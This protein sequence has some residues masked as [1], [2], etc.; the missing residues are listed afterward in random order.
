MFGELSFLFLLPIF[1]S[2]LS[3]LLNLLCFPFNLPLHHLF[4][5][6]SI[7]F[8][9]RKGSVNWPNVFETPIGLFRISAKLE[10]F[11]DFFRK[12]IGISFVSSHHFV[13]KNFGALF[14]SI[15]KLIP[16]YWRGS[17][18][19]RETTVYPY[20]IFLLCHWGCCSVLKF[21]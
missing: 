21:D 11:Y 14:W 19:S 2:L 9:V 7:T 16:I 10:C 6:E 13:P 12:F 4:T 8:G 1:E 18:L 3:L 15:L 17:I 5:L 20:C